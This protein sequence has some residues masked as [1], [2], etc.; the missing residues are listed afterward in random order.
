MELYIGLPIDRTN[1]ILYFNLRDE[2]KQVPGPPE[3][4]FNGKFFTLA[5]L[6]GNLCACSY[7]LGLDSLLVMEMKQ[8]G[9]KESWTRVCSININQGNNWM[10]PLAFTKKAELVTPVNRKE[11]AIYSVED[12]SSK[13]IMRFGEVMGPKSMGIYADSS[14]ALDCDCLLNTKGRN[15]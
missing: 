11:L 14:I 5:A 4:I 15:S 8:Y 1:E 10:T 6:R 7:G 13:T 2:F 9:V 12:N 3:E